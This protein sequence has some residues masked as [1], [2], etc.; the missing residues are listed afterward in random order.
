MADDL[1]T[2]KNG[3]VQINI[4]DQKMRVTIR[5]N[6][7]TDEH[8]PQL[9]L[10][11][12]LN[13][14]DK[15]GI[16]SGINEEIITQ[17]IEEK[18]WGDL[19]VAAEGSY[20]GTG[21]DANIEYYFQT[22]KSL[23]PRISE[24]GHINYKEVDLVGSV[25]KDDILIKKIPA[26]KGS[27]GKNVMGDELPGKTGKDINVTAGQGTYKDPADAMIIKAAADGIIS[28]NPKTNIVEVQKLY[29]ING[30]VDFSTG[31]VNVK[32]SVD[33]KGDVSSGFSITTPY[34]VSVKG[35]VEH[36]TISC[37]GTLTVKG[38]IVGDVQQVIKV[39]GDVHSGYIRNQR[40]KCGG[41]VYAATEI[42][43]SVI[44]CG[45]E[46]TLTKPDGKIVGGKVIASNKIAAGT[47][48][49]KYDVPTEIE[50]GMNFEHR[51]KYLKK[52]ELVTEAH[53]QADEIKKK[54]D[55]INS[56]PP[57]IGTNARYKAL[58]EQ[59][60]AAVG[61]WERMCEELKIIEKDYFNIEDPVVRVSKS[62][63]PGVTIKIKH[64]VYEVK[65]ELTHVM[66]RLNG[67]QIEYNPLK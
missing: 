10:Q 51:E 40:I 63:Y 59:Y 21:E 46:V 12:V 1:K 32:S 52:Y 50:V 48:G 64:V 37:E 3:K 8:D 56:R 55:I 62:V 44:E 39:G 4:I 5:I 18:K 33:I 67:D 65:N 24:D 27:N 34:N 38:G 7:P 6:P 15:A 11:D 42:L 54:I 53:K 66:F 61:Q 9:V 45:E 28:F 57:D 26:T 43:S 23:K 14:L 19:F 31:N 35:L 58:K 36:A 16:K 22:T 13:E 25:S 29:V 17:Y 2:E 47:I 49:N 20:P 30:S 60:Q 41:S